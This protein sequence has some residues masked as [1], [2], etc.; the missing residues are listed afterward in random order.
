MV[1]KTIIV[2]NLYDLLGFACFSITAFIDG[3]VAVLENKKS[4]NISSGNTSIKTP[5]QKLKFKCKLSLC[6]SYV[7]KAP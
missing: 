7:D 5:E 4:R 3:K 6:A 2:Y 1:I